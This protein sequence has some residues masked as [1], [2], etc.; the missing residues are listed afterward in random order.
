MTVMIKMSDGNT[1]VLPGGA[2]LSVTDAGHLIVHGPG[3]AAPTIAVIEAKRWTSAE[4]VEA[5]KE[6]NER[7]NGTG[8]LST[9]RS[10]LRPGPH[11][12]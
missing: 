7:Q 4:V 1:E 9:S 8:G 3:G 6:R 11:P 2:T 5:K 10:S 12:G